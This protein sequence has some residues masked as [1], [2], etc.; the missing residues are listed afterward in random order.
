MPARLLQACAPRRNAS[1]SHYS[2]IDSRADDDDDVVDEKFNNTG[3]KSAIREY[4]ADEAL[5]CYQFSMKQPY[6]ARHHAMRALNTQALS[7][8]DEGNRLR[9]IDER[10]CAMM[11]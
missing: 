2:F 10:R 6:H 9:F 11:S 1:L 5:L 4:W 7:F 3:L 8:E